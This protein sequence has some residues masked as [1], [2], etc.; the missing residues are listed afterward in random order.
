VQ[1]LVTLLTIYIIIR[2]FVARSPRS[3]L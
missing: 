3:V 2:Y 1:I